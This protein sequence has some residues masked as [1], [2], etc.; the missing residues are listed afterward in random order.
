MAVLED[1]IVE[2]PTVRTF[3]LRPGDPMPFRTGQFAQLTLPGVGEAPFPPSSSPHEAERIEVTV[4]R[5]G[6][7]IEALHEVEVQA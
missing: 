7:V 4:M 2:T 6:R 3:V 1:V 5:T